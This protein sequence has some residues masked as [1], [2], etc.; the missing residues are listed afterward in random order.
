MNLQEMALR[1][2]IPH[3]TSFERLAKEGYMIMEHGSGLTVRDI[4]GVEYLD[5]MSAGPRATAVGYGRKEIAQS[6]AKQAEEMCFFTP[7]GATTRVTIELAEKMGQISPGD[8]NHI[9]F[10]CGGSEAVESAFKLARRHHLAKGDKRRFK[11]ISRRGA[12]HGATLGAGSATGSM[13]PMRELMEPTA[14]GFGFIPAPTCYRCPFRKTYGN[15]QIDCALYLEDTIKFESPEL[16]S[17]FIMEP[18]M[19]FNGC[20]VPPQKYYEM[21]RSICK[22]YGVLLIFDEIITG[23]GRTGTMFCTEQTGVVP[24]MMT[25]GKGFTSGYAPLAGVVASDAV[26]KPL[27]MFFHIHT[28]GGHPVGCAAALTNIQII[29]REDLVNNSNQMGK[30]LVE[31]LKKIRDYDIVGETRGIGLWAAVELVKN[32]ETREPFAVADE[33]PAR[34]AR[35]AKQEGVIIG[36]IGNSIEL[37]PALTVSTTQIDKALTVLEKAIGQV[38]KEIKK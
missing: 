18:V 9:F 17:A 38:C 2:I 27:D 7:D 15:C 6:M 13:S 22:Q 14:P 12:F 11:V 3:R 24:D 28:F 5:M 20:Q 35:Y 32:K 25:V 29:E 30:R 33:V 34:V 31:G 1:R 4:N 19:Q 21:V 26:I 16:V 36:S 37:A 10:V 8:L 23:F